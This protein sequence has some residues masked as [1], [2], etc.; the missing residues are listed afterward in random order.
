MSRKTGERDSGVNPLGAVPR[1]PITIFQLIQKL[2]PLPGKKTPTCLPQRAKNA[3]EYVSCTQTAMSDNLD[4]G[5]I[6]EIK[7]SN[8]VFRNKNLVLGRIFV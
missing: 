3:A 2:K 6:Q 1:G 5:A 4:E 8:F 7:P